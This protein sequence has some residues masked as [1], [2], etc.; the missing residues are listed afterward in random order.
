A[1]LIEMSAGELQQGSAFTWFHLNGECR[2]R[3]TV[4]RARQ[5]VVF[6]AQKRPARQHGDTVAS[7]PKIH[8]LAKLRVHV[9]QSLEFRK[10]IHTPGPLRASIHFLK[11]D[12]V[13]F[14]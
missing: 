4:R 12:D 2:A 10:L 7:T 6:C 3:F 11:S 9:C 5:R 13:W 14:D 1:T 8:G